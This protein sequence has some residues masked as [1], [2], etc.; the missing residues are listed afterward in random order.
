MPSKCL[1]KQVAWRAGALH[2]GGVPLQNAAPVLGG[3]GGLEGGSKG[4]LSCFH[5]FHAY[6][7]TKPLALSQSLSLCHS[8]GGGGGVLL[9]LSAVLIHPLRPPPHPISK[10]EPKLSDI[11]I[12]EISLWPLEPL[13][14]SPPPMNLGGGSS[15]GCQPF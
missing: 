1:T 6:P 7:M 5:V 14:A 2:R 11:C 3:G 12:E 9:R 15:S 10:L 4:R 8:K 13:S